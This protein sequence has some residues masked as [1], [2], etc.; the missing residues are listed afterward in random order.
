MAQTT[1]ELL[2]ELEAEDSRVS[3]QLADI[4]HDL[5]EAKL[6]LVFEMHSVQVGSTVESRGRTFQV[7]KIICRDMRYPW[8]EGFPAKKG[9]GWSKREQWIGPDWKVITP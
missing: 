9:G 1:Q 4:R 5:N 8:L 6:R 2:N 7:S 3:A